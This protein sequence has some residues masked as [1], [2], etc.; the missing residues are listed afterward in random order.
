MTIDFSKVAAETVVAKEA[1]FPTAGTGRRQQPDPALVE[2]IKAAAKD[3]QRRELGGRF[4]V[5]PYPG[6]QHANESSTVV[7]ALHRAAKAAGV[8][9]AVR[10]FDPTTDGVR[11]TYRVQDAN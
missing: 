6:R 1:D 2:L 7:A 9:I 3:K 11:L 8:K 5:Q 4:S 10:K